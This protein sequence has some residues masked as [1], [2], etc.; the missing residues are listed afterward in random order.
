M[1]MIFGEIEEVRRGLLKKVV[2]FGNWI[3]FS[4]YLEGGLYR[5]AFHSGASFKEADIVEVILV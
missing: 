3:S 1:A 5:R 4:D 2:T